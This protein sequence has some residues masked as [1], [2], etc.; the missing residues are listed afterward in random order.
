M[1]SPSVSRC[2]GR[3][4]RR[5]VKSMG[6]LQSTSTMAA[7]ASSH[8]Q[9]TSTVQYNEKMDFSTAMTA[10]P[11]HAYGSEYHEEQLKFLLSAFQAIS[12]ETEESPKAMEHAKA[13]AKAV[14][15][16]LMNAAAAARDTELYDKILI[17]IR[18]GESAY[19][20]FEKEWAESGNDPDGA[21]L[22]EKYPRD[23]LMTGKGCGQ[24][25][26]LARRTAIFCNDETG[27]VP[28]LFV[29]SPLKRAVQSALLSFP[30]FA[31]GSVR[32]TPWICHGDLM[33]RAGFKADFV[34]P[35]DELEEF[36]PGIDYSHY[37]KTMNPAVVNSLEGRNI[38]E[39]KKELLERTNDFLGWIKAR[40]E[41][42]IVVA[43]HSTWF[44][45]FCGFTLKYEPEGNGATMFEEGEMR[46]LGIKFD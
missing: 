2:T 46:S 5:A 22:S 35:A 32:D 45:S 17:L 40:D 27:L 33:E 24:V 1:L 28:E 25:L 13:S 39:S 38:V 18:P 37:R 10:E 15:M 21:L 41:R 11:N 44:Q 16:D 4:V 30:S 29:V 36:F 43:S 9:L 6:R 7:V 42:V 12:S 19:S 20:L 3:L 31:P 23:G 14:E 34:S 26:D 8:Q